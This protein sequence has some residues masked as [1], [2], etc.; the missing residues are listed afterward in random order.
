M[1]QGRLFSVSKREVN[2]LTRFISTHEGDKVVARWSGTGTQRGPFLGIAPANRQM[3][4]TAIEIMRIAEGDK[5]VLRF[6]A[7]G[8]H[9]GPFAGLPPTDKQVSVAG[10]NIYRLAHGKIAES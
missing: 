5:V 9:Q 4:I 8:T 3:I 10:I 2:R 6:V 1:I 7:C